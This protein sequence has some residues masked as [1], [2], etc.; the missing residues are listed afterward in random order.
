MTPYDSKFANCHDNRWSENVDTLWGSFSSCQDLLLQRVLPKR[1]YY[2]YL[3]KTK[4][5]YGCAFVSKLG[6]SNRDTWDFSRMSC[7]VSFTQCSGA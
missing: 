6:L 5:N 7:V 3:Q 1:D 4:K 2:I